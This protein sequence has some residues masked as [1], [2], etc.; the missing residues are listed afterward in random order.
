MSRDAG[1]VPQDDPLA[2]FLTWTTYGSW[3]PGDER[4][5][6]EKPGNIMS[7]DP[8]RESEAAERMHDSEVLLDSEQRDLVERT[9]ADHCRHRD[10]HLHAVNCRTQHVHV[11]ATA[12]QRKP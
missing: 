4:G 5:W 7:P 1:R 11:V 8:E 2:F 12:P 10:W 3:L 6:V 9:V